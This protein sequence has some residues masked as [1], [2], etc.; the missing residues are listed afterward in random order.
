[1]ATSTRGDLSRIRTQAMA[2]DPAL[3]ERMQASAL[4]ADELARRSAEARA[5]TNNLPAVRAARRAGGLRTIT[6]AQR[7]RRAALEATVRAAGYPD[8]TTAIA[9]TRMMPSRA[10]A[11]RLGIGAST[12]KRWRQKERS[13]TT[14]PV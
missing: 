1:M 14:D 12:V 2:D 10:A 4:P 8:V 11:A 5:G 3:I 7:A 13:Q 6:E 9:A